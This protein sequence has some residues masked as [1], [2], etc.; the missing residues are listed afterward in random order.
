MIAALMRI[1][2]TGSTHHPFFQRVAMTAMMIAA[3]LLQHTAA[4]VEGATFI[5]VLKHSMRT[6]A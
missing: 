6:S 4:R 3:K 1:P 5:L 2:P